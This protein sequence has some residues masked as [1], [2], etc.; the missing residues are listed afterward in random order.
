MNPWTRRLAAAAVVPLV[1]YC[2]YAA[3]TWL[4]YGHP[5]APREHER[6]PLL[7]RF[8]QAYDVREHDAVQVDAP[9]AVAFAAAGQMDLFDVPAVRA[10]VRAREL[11]LRATPDSRPRP[12]GLIAETQSIGWGVLAHVPDR[13]IV[14]GA[15]TQPWRAN[16]VFRA[17]PP[18]EFAEFHEPGYVKIAWTLRVDP[19][20][21]GRSLFSTE[22]RAVAT[23]ATA[24]AR[25]RRY[26]AF[27]SPGIIL[28]RV[29]AASALRTELARGPV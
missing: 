2:A 1:S 17:L 5:A 7:D 14:M 6:D 18:A 22:T 11:I 27:L 10:I 25:F 19:I 29:A 9:A 8:I 28:I 24:R 4:G 13:E 15:V 21:G 16:V 20:D 12:H 3:I 23:D 26:W